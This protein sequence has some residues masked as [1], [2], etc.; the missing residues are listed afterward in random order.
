MALAQP[1]KILAISPHLDDAVFACG[2]LLARFPGGVVVTVFA[3]APLDGGMLTTWDAAC[4][5]SNAAQ[6]LASRRE[7]DSAALRFLSATPRWFDFCDSQYNAPLSL[8]SLVNAIG[9]AIDEVRPSTLLLP[10][11]LFHS[12]HILVHEASLQLRGHYP[13]LNWLM[14]EEPSYRRVA[15]LLQQRLAALAAGGIQATPADAGDRAE[16]SRKRDAVRCYA[17]QL[18][19]LERTVQGGYADV[20]A[21]ER[22]WRLDAVPGSRGTSE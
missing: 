20:F 9:E 1:G 18:H 17:S 10:A 4:G 16:A 13:E 8:P 3:G 6:A 14:Y 21:P 7:E 2:D 15:G 12:D 19:A 11:G 22:Y 5:F